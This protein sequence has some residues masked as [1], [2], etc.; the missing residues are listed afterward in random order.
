[1]S[2]VSRLEMLTLIFP[3][4]GNE[5]N[6]SAILTTGFPEHHRFSSY[7]NDKGNLNFW[8]QESLVLH[9]HKPC[10]ETSTRV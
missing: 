7:W 3:K 1:M 10:L 9:F 4:R 2:I 8:T 6:N 5:R